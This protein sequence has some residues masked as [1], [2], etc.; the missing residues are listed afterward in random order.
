MGMGK[1]P[2]PPKPAPV[3]PVPQEDDPQS[4]EAQQKAAVVASQK[5]GASA[6]LLS[7]EKGVTEDPETKRKSLTGSML[8]TQ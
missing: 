2:D 8:L 4:Y 5:D 7:G 1:A 3:V 6:H